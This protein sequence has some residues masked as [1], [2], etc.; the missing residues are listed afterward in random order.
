MSE[1]TVKSKE[2]VSEVEAYKAKYGKVYRIDATVEQDDS[3]STEYHY[4]FRKPLTASYDRYI[5][6]MSQSPT[7]AT[8]RF[9]LDNVVDEQA[10]QLEAHLDEYPA[11]CLSIGEK[12]LAMLGLTK[13]VNLKQL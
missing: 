7:K 6:S 8:R 13:E 4:Y 1:N 3:T 9:A 12:L 2:G 5:K 11:F 10:N